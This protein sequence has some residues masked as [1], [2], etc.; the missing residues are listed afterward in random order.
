MDQMYREASMLLTGVDS[1]GVAGI[2]ATEEEV[3]VAEQDRIWRM[4]VLQNLFL[5]QEEE[6]GVALTSEV[7]KTAE[8]VIMEGHHDAVDVSN[9]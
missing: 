1:D 6:V 7:N 3:V 4:V 5:V 9:T 2:H 8:G